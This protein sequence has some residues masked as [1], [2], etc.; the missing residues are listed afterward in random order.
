MRPS[1]E[2]AVL[3]FADGACLPDL[4]VS[5][6]QSS[7]LSSLLDK[8]N[9]S[10]YGARGDESYVYGWLATM[11]ND[12]CMQLSRT[13]LSSMPL[14]LFALFRLQPGSYVHFRRQHRLPTATCCFVS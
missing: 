5:R 14:E 4:V 7:S 10:C 9:D 2:G 6:C 8:T 1:S 3:A 12:N 13:S 11:Y